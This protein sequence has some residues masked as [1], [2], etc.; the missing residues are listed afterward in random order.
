MNRRMI[1][2]IAVLLAAL[3][4]SCKTGLKV[5]MINNTGQDITVVSVNPGM[6]DAATPIEPGA[7]AEF[8]VPQKLKV[9][10]K[11]VTWNY[12]PRPVPS[13]FEKRHGAFYRQVFQIERDGAIYLVPPQRKKPA[14]ELPDQPR[15]FPL[16]PK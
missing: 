13:K 14:A 12:E 8:R 4:T 3:Q 6:E 9:I 16:R 2:L 15:D 10:E 7:L 5:Y 1:P 11:G